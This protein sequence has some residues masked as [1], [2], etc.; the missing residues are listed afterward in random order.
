VR[1][2]GKAVIGAPGAIASVHPDATRATAN[3]IGPK[4]FMISP[5]KRVEVNRWFSRPH[6]PRPD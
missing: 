2:R 5:L 4:S 6:L 3:N 1:S